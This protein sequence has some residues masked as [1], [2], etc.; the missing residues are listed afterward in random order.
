MKLETSLIHAQSQLGEGPLWHPGEQTLYWVD[1]HQGKVETYQ[2]AS[3]QRNTIQFPFVVT[4]LGI[5]SAGG[6]VAA[7]SRGIGY[8]DGA[9]SQIELAARPE[10]HLPG[11]RFNDG[12]VGPDGNFWAGTMS[13]QVDLQSPPPG[14]LYRFHPDKSIDRIEHSIHISNGLGWSPDHSHFYLTDSPRKTIYRYSYDLESGAI[15]DRQVWVHSP[16]EAGVPDGLAVDAEGCVWSARWGGWKISRYDPDGKLMQEIQLPV[17]HPTSCAFGGPDLDELFITSAWT[18]VN[19]HQRAEQPLA[20]DVF[21][22][23]LNVKGL[24]VFLFSG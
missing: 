11:N 20:G 16:D 19:A 18:P 22:I 24:P 8:W 1:I 2:P 5:R 12:A 3:Q 9:S 17:E 21:H 23:Q 15:T 6:F 7:T 13:E 4:A 14:S 10:E